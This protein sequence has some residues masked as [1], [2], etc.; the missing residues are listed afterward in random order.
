MK[1]KLF[2]LLVLSSLLLP[3]ATVPALRA[4][5]Q[6]KTA[7]PVL[8]DESADGAKQIA[9]ALVIAKRDGKNVL[10]QFGANWC[11]WCR[12]LHT[13]FETNPE[14]AETLKKNYVV[15]LIDVNKQHNAETD[16]KYG[17][18]IRFG[19][20]VLVVLD[21]DGKQLHTQDS[22]KLEEGD[23]HSPEKVL[24]FLKAWIPKKP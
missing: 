19:L 17:H 11:G 13:L 21:A 2:S 16:T 10:L 9:D 15:V 22:G 3:L 18:P 24:T 5:D 8:Y 23:H 14:I 1:T 4:E 12:K 6:P 20:P 7:R